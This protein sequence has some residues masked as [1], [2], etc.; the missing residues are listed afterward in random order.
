MSGILHATSKEKKRDKKNYILRQMEYIFVTRKNKSSKILF[1]PL[2][3][4]F[5]FVGYRCSC[6]FLLGM[7]LMRV[8]D[9]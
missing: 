8:G 5:S 9:S 7:V 2:G 1:F 4:M 3:S 6:L